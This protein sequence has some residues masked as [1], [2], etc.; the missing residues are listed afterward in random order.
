MVIVLIPSQFHDMYEHTSGTGSI[1]F[2]FQAA[3]SL[4]G[5]T[6]AVAM[7]TPDPIL[8]LTILFTICPDA[9]VDTALTFLALL[10]CKAD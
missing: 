9:K 7:I 4:L 3:R 5:V 2:S 6:D 1:G 8:A 10:G